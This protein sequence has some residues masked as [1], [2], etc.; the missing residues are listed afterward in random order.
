[1][2]KQNSDY[3]V[4]ENP[5]LLEAL[6][7]EPSKVLP[8]LHDAMVD[9][10]FMIQGQLGYANGYPPA[11]EANQPGRLDSD[12]E[13]MGYYER[14]R[15]WW[16]PVKRKETLAGMDSVAEGAQT[17]KSALRRHKI[18]NVA[19]T[20]KLVVRAGGVVVKRGVPVFQNI[21]VVSEKRDYVAGYKLAKNKNG[22][23]GTSEQLGKS[24][25]TRVTSDET[26]VQGEVGTP[27]SYADFVQ[28]FSVIALH[29]ERG[30]IDMDTRVEAL[31][32]EI[33]ARVDKALADYLSSITGE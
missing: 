29:R 8:F 9:V 22:Q 15:G 26:M 27:V 12:G 1:M 17:L 5:E 31:V 21:T 24:W 16:Y 25:T 28:G 4:I 19:T 7:M 6:K 10:T 33:E 14:N 13:P 30:W 2:A 20:D 32:P 18:K 11:S 23:R 3:F